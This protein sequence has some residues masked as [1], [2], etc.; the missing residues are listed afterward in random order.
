MV[1][2]QATG[3]FDFITEAVLPMSFRSASYGTCSTCGEYERRARQLHEPN[4]G[5][6]KIFRR[7]QRITRTETSEL[8]NLQALN[9]NATRP[10]GHPLSLTCL[11]QAGLTTSQ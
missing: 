11:S 4:F 5:A 6:V 3:S 10:M 7:W 9:R 1:D 8:S 2:E